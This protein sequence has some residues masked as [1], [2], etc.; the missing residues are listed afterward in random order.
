M[1]GKHFFIGLILFIISFLLCLDLFISKGR[2]STFDGPTHLANIA[3]FTKALRDKDFPVR[4]TDGFGNYGMPMGIIVQQTTS[5]LGAIAALITNNIFLSYN[6]VVLIGAFIS[7]YLLFHFFILHFSENASLLG[8]ILFNF[9]PYRIINI[10]VRGAIPEFFSHVFFPIIFIGLFLLIKNRDLRGLIHL[11]IGFVGILLTHPFTLIIGMFLWVPYSIW[12]MYNNK[13]NV[14]FLTSNIPRILLTLVLVFGLSAFYIFPLYQEIKYFYYGIGNHYIPGNYLTLKNYLGDQWYYFYYNDIDVR[15]HIIHLGL[16]EL[17]ILLS[18]II[19]FISYRKKINSFIYWVIPSGFIIIF[20]TLHYADF[21]YTRISLLGNIQHNWRMFTS[22]VF[23]APFILASL[24]DKLKSKKIFILLLFIIIVFR[25]PQLY[26]KNYLIEKQE[27][28]YW[29]KVNLHG[30]IMNTVWT[31]PTEDYPVKKI[32]G[33]IIE[34]LGIIEKRDEHN[35][36]RKYEVIAKTE[37][38]LVDNTF[39]F[40]G[41]KA[42]VDGKETPIEFQDMNHRGVIT[43]RVPQGKHSIKVEFVD[44]KI[45]MAAN[46]ISII[47]IGV[48]GILILLRKR[49]FYHPTK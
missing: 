48:V 24:T 1:F 36:W 23:I 39:Y 22:L 5:Y 19:G 16:I 27:K 34:G 15:G 13:K 37:L 9:A 30:N 33:E 43:Y 8:V 49:L 4:W 12:L 20:F 6:L 11:L 14:R 28:Y 44:T 17:I 3:Q 38:R 47:S 18:G 2:P 40:P 45:R 21:I 10:Y 25:F 46:I 29:S 35:S 26:G 42:Y 32:K 41:W 31:G 7:T